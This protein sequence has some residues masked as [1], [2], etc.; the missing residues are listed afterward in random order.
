MVSI[1]ELETAKFNF[2]LLPNGYHYQLKNLEILRREKHKWD[3]KKEK[4]ANNSV[5]AQ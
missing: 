1:L 4:K 5:L 3:L 2:V